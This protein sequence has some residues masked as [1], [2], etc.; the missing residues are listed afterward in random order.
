MMRSAKS[1]Y[2]QESDKDPSNVF[3]YFLLELDERMSDI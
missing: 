3:L 1:F 2:Q